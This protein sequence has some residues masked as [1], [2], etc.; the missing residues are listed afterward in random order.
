L[1]LWMILGK[2]LILLDF[3]FDLIHQ[4]I[5]CIIIR[6]NLYSIFDSVKSLFKLL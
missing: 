5:H 1:T 2:P 6:L 4:L 3:N